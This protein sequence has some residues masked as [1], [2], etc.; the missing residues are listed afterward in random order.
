[1]LKKYLYELAEASGKYSCGSI[2]ASSDTEAIERFSQDALHYLGRV[3]YDT[4]TDS[5]NE[6]VIVESEIPLFAG[7]DHREGR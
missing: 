4:D 3:D 6:I 7:E 5:F 2:F 1:M